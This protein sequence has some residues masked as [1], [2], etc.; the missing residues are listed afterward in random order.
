MD[1]AVKTMLFQNHAVR[2][3]QRLRNSVTI[4]ECDRQLVLREAAVCTSM[5]HP[6]VVATYHYEV[7]QVQSYEESPSGLS[8]SDQ[9]GEV[10]FKL[11]LIQV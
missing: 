10:A 2:G 3:H 6:N 5:A 11:Y 1:V 7:L 4:K 9:S 8:I